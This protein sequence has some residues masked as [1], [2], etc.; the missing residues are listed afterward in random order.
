MSI[1]MTCRTREKE[2]GQWVYAR[3]LDVRA[4]RT[5]GLLRTPRFR[6]PVLGSPV[7]FSPPRAI[8]SYTFSRNRQR[9][10][11]S[12]GILGVFLE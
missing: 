8:L 6:T 10:R 2:T 9:D 1:N 3:Y 4:S 7:G 11:T 5:N 12:Q